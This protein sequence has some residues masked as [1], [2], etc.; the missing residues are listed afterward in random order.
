MPLSAANLA[1]A[2]QASGSIPFVLQAV[3]NI[4]GGPRG[5]YWDGGITD[6][7]LHLPYAAMADGL[8][9]YP[10]FQRALVPG[11][12]D[13]GLKRRHVAT[14][15]LDNVVVLAPRSEWVATLPHCKLPD[16]QDFKIWQHDRAGRI[17]AWTQAVA[18]AQ[19]LA[20][21]AANWLATPTQDALPL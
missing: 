4:P 18:A 10:H 3:H 21:E 14:A 5:A 13:K 9:L 11:W 20:D 19:Q 15:R 1:P 6:Y 7:H 8:V 16:R 2:M 17:A 12:L